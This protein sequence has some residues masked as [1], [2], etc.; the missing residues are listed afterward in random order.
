MRSSNTL[1][2]LV[3][4]ALA[5]SPSGL[6]C[7]VA[8]D[9]ACLRHSDCSSGRV[10]SQGRCMTDPSD[11]SSLTDGAVTDGAVLYGEGGVDG[12]ASDASDQGD[13]TD[14]GVDTGSDTASGDAG[15]GPTEGDA[16]GLIDAVDGTA[17]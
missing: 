5:L 8:D 6:G 15:D 2:R 16:P 14:S 17:D 10:C 3:A 11:Q 9:A 1:A 7:Q 12:D 13:V 4:L